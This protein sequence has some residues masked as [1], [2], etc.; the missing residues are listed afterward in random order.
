MIAPPRIDESQ[1]E[2]KAESINKIFKKYFDI[3]Y[4]S[5]YNNGSSLDIRRE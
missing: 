1:L 3:I 5:D 4:V 2:D